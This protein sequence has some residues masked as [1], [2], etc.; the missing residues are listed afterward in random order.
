VSYTLNQPASVRFVVTRLL[1]GQRAAGG[2]CVAPSP[3]NRRASKCMRLVTVR[4]A[5]TRSGALGA[6]RF[7][8][9]G[10]IGGH[11]LSP[12]AYRLVAV[13]GAGPTR[14]SPIAISFR[15]IAPT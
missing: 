6:N 1:M 4:A 3:S 2:R 5:F 14:G 13:P 10:R 8:F 11:R 12:G 9:T 15:I 7:R